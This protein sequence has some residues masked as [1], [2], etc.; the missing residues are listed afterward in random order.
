MSDP[1]EKPTKRPIRE[2][3]QYIE[4]RLSSVGVRKLWGGAG[5]L[6]LLVG[7]LWL[8]KPWAASPES[9]ISAASRTPTGTQ[10]ELQALAV[11]ALPS[12]TTRAASPTQ[13]AATQSTPTHTRVPTETHATSATPPP[14]VLPTSTPIIHVVQQGEHLGKLASQYDTDMESIA[15]ANNIE[16]DSILRIGQELIIPGPTAAPTTAPDE[17]SSLNI[18]T[19]TPFPTPTPRPTSTPFIHVVQQGEHLGIIASRYDTDMESI[20]EANGIEVDSILQIGQQLIIPPPTATAT[21]GPPLPATAT[22][23]AR[24]TETSTSTRRLSPPPSP[25]VLPTREP[26]VHV[27][28]AGEHLG[29]LAEK[30]N[31]TSEAI[32]RANQIG[33]DDILQIGQELIIPSSGEQS[34]VPTSKDTPAPTLAPA[35]HIVQVGETLGEIAMKY[36]VSVEEIA[37]ASG[38][39]VDSVLKIGAVLIIPGITLTP[40]PTQEPP[41]TPT[42]TP[43]PTRMATLSPGLR[44]TPQYPYRQVYLLGPIKNS[45]F[46][47][48]EAR[49]LLNWSS[50]GILADEEWYML[51]IWLSDESDTPI[52]IW[53]Q[54]TSWRVPKSFYAEEKAP[55]DFSW[56]VTVVERE[57][58]NQPSVAISPD[59]QIYKFR[60]D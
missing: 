38:I 23:T 35:V 14:T 28:Q 49:I 46:R 7:V 27:I 37:E 59:S 8:S 60:W 33:I 11:Q 3:L 12:S 51:S 1:T 34:P 39:D 56:Q 4:K 6:V 43:Q 57:E 22:H 52:T 48:P 16:V 20:A 32:A 53:T 2:A 24:P 26:I 50:V 5:L 42:R 30:Y 45:V 18:P 31:V 58:E 10:S 41:L 21:S 13:T 15:N 54:A 25:T 19:A 29:V 55:L 36:D 47:G 9:A 44:T 17:A 40:E